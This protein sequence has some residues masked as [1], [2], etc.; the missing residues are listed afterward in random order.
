VSRDD[1]WHIDYGRAVDVSR[2]NVWQRATDLG[3]LR[4][5]IRLHRRDH[6]V[7]AAQV[8]AT[9][10]VQEFERLTHARGVAEEDLQLT[11]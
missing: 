6:D 8:P 9:A 4:G 11:A 1:G 2:G 3:D 10:L 7:F 5:H